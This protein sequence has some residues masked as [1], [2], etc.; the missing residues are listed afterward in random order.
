MVPSSHFTAHL[1]QGDVV[2]LF[3]ERARAAVCASSYSSEADDPFATHTTASSSE[4][5]YEDE[6]ATVSAQ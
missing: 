1:R 3:P 5:W 6:L 4:R 2:S